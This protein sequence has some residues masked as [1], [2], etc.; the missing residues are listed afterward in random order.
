I[1][2]VAID[3]EDGSNVSEAKTATVKVPGEEDEDEHEE[4]ENEENEDDN[5]GNM[6]PV[7]S[8]SA[9]YDPEQSIIDVTWNYNGPPAMFEVIVKPDGQTQMVNSKGIEISGANPGETYT[10]TVTPVGQN[11]AN[12]DVKGDPQQ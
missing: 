1:E 2:V 11:G 12:E 5:A 8:L 7:T 6:M 9:A 10:I 3:N 4:D